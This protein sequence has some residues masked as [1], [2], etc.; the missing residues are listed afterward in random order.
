MERGEDGVRGD[1][2]ARHNENG[3]SG[4]QRPVTIYQIAR[5]LGVS[6]G[7]VS[8]AL[9][10]SNLV[11]PD[12][13]ERVTRTAEEMGYLK[14]RIRRHRA[15]AILNVALFLPFGGE[16]YLHLFYDPAEFIHALHT[17]FGEVR[18]NVI[19]LTD[20]SG[21]SI[22]EHKKHGEI[23]ACV[24]GFTTPTPELLAAIDE[25]RVPVV[26][27]NRI[28]PQHN[29]VASDHAA[30]M[31][32]LLAHVLELNPYP[33]PCFLGLP[34]IPQVSELRRDGLLRAAA[35]R[36]VRLSTDDTW[37]L[38]SLGEIT[39]RL[40]EGLI[41]TGYDTVMC[42]NDVVA[43]YIYQCALSMG[44]RIPE[45][46]SLTGFDNSPVRSLVSQPITTVDLTVSELGRRAGAWL[47]ERIIE[48]SD[49][50]L[51]LQVPGELVAGTTVAARPDRAR[52]GGGG[53]YG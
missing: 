24:F 44:L 30:G 32:R 19:T 51:Q 41:A 14:R 13:H 34:A 49:E 18:A 16:N 17:G 15:R 35:S 29:Y 8:R 21:V 2:D 25:R 3:S 23:D 10:G 1:S 28:D 9:N 36:G 52:G 4:E 33:R 38:G 45:V 53:G 39:P 27:I 6:A 42:F 11:A 5:E 31:E 48:R 47:R 20:A 22:F 40:I 43:V 12:T 50:S 37:D 26:L 46:F 7:T